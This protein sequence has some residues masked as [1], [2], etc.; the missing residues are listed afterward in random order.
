MARCFFLRAKR[1]LFSQPKASIHA[2]LSLEICFSFPSDECGQVRVA[3]AETRLHSVEGQVV[4]K[5]E[6]RYYLKL[7]EAPRWHK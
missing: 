3:G 5:G 7:R 4:R 2:Q 6:R 1:R